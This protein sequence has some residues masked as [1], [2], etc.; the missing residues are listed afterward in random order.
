[1]FFICMT[2]AVRGFILSHLIN[3]QQSDAPEKQHLRYM[4]TNHTLPTNFK[5]DL[6]KYSRNI[7][8]SYWAPSLGVGAGVE[9]NI[10]Y[11][12]GAFLPRFL[13]LNLTAALDGIPLNIGEL[14]ARVQGL[15]PI[16]AQLFG[17]GGYLQTS[18]YEKVV[19]DVL[20]YVQKNW[21]K[22]VQ[23]WENLRHRRS[24]GESLLSSI[25]SYSDRPLW[26]EADM[27]ARFMGQ[28]FSFASLAG[29]LRHFDG[30]RFIEDLMEK[31]QEM[32]PD[33][34]N[35]NVDSA[36]IAYINVDYFFPTIQGSPLKLQ[37]NT[38]AVASLKMQGNLPSLLS[39]WPRGQNMVNV[40][41]SFTVETN[42]FVG[43]DSNIAKIGLQSNA[44]VS[45]ANGIVVKVSGSSDSEL[46]VE[47][48]LPSKMEIFNAE[49][50]TYLMKKR[51][52]EPETKTNPSSMR[53]ERYTRRS[54]ITTM[55][56]ILGLKM[57]YDID[58]PNIVGSN[59]L[60]LV[61]RPIK[62]KIN[63]E[64][65]EAGLTGY[66][67]ALLMQHEGDNKSWNGKVSTKGSLSAREAH[68][69]AEFKKQQGNYTTLI[70]LDSPTLKGKVETNLVHRKN[71]TTIVTFSEVSTHS[72]STGRGIKIDLKKSTPSSGNGREYDVQVYYS[73]SQQFSPN[74]VLFTAKYKQENRD[75]KMDLEFITS[76]KNALRNYIPIDFHGK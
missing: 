17:P 52:G 65:V 64:N 14:G 30:A 59:S 39:G 1:M 28:E 41:P 55:E 38:T 46:Q 50:E 12:P 8:L 66:K 73:Q 11:S 42:A 71:R 5:A 18:S 37:L 25:L 22:I 44:T 70:H 62:T 34:R 24:T 3:L 32:L 35:I 36:R 21:Q 51:S 9:S 72:E 75:P 57:C 31:V 10:I 33:L 58:I 6:R 53:D 48:D 2:F 26:A 13:D 40:T 61:S 20:E 4:L 68:I 29:D 67:M 23:E 49:S 54:C 15:E 45:S 63:L 74:S 76:T 16:I 19:Q 47:L 43:F 7:D 60:P 69:K 56:S 27:F